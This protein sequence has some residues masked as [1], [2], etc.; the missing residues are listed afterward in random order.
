MKHIAA[1]YAYLMERERIRLAK[2]EN[3]PWPWTQDK[4]LQ[5]YKFTNVRREHDRTSQE[6]RRFYTQHFKA[7][8]EEIL[9]NCTI[10]RYF[11]T[12][13]FLLT[14]GWQTEFNAA[15]IKKLA[16]QRLAANERVFTGA[17]V[18]TNQGISAPKQEVVVD[19]FLKD[20]WA[21]RKE[22]L[23][24]VADTGSWE[25]TLHRLQQVQGFGGSGFMAKEVTLDTMYFHKFWPIT[26]GRGASVPRDYDTWTPIGPGAQRGLVRVYEDTSPREEPALGKKYGL[27]DLLAI[28]ALQ[29]TYKWPLAWG[30]LSPT[31]IQFGLC[32]FDKYRR[33]QLKEGTPR[34]RYRAP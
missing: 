17:Y 12:S 5:E 21:A 33:V 6:F 10:A 23:K 11:G 31:D 2:V 24:V 18:I 20:V 9:L 26:K 32:E 8:S 15:R 25:K 29:D 16:T 1:F 27:R 22:I 13:E 14:L 7:A 30:K 4:I 19:Y 3:K 34:S 28:H